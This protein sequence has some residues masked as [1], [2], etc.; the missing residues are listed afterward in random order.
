[1]RGKGKTLLDVVNKL[2]NTK[3]WFTNFPPH[4][5]EGR[6][7]SLLSGGFTTKVRTLT[8]AVIN[9]PE[10][11]LAKLCALLRPYYTAKRTKENLISNI[12]LLSPQK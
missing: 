9:P 7:A 1:M 2:L 12:H 8:K 3:N 10:R 4:Y 6:F 5:T 11:K